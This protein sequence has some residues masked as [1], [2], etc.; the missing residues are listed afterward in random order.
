VLEQQTNAYAPCCRRASGAATGRHRGRQGPLQAPGGAIRRPSC[1]QRSPRRPWRAIWRA[2]CMCACW[3]VI[4]RTGWLLP[5]HGWGGRSWPATREFPRSARDAEKPA[6]EINTHCNS[7]RGPA[8]RRKEDAS[9]KWRPEELVSRDKG[10]L[11]EAQTGV[12]R[13]VGLRTIPAQRL[14][15]PPPCTDRPVCARAAQRD[16]LSEKFTLGT[17]L[18][19]RLRQTIVTSP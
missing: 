12:V 17:N 16:R 9:N 4:P 13:C 14:F 3:P 19:N 7:R 15:N 10:P 5:W 8:D 6:P 11:G 2:R 1:C 18:K